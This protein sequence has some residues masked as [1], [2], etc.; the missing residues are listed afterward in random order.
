M[1]L[2]QSESVKCRVKRAQTLRQYSKC[3]NITDKDNNTKYFHSLVSINKKRM[4]I[5]RIKIG[6]K[7][8]D[9]KEEIREI[10]RNYYKKSFE[11]EPLPFTYLLSGLLNQLSPEQA[12]EL[13]SLPT[14]DEMKVVVWSCDP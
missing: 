1:K 13:E 4:L 7:W 8:L 2:L 12:A 6:E 9:G 11:Q 5:T 10:V 3:K 14:D